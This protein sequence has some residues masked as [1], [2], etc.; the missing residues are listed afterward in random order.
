MD[1]AEELRQQAVAGDGVGDAGL[2]HHHH[3]HHRGQAGDGADLDQGLRGPHPNALAGASFGIGFGNNPLC[4]FDV[5]A[6]GQVAVQA[7]RAVASTGTTTVTSANG[8]ISIGIPFT[9]EVEID[10]A[11]TGGITVSLNG[12]SV[13]TGTL[14]DAPANSDSANLTRFY[15]F[16]SNNN[17]AAYANMRF[18]DHIFTQRSMSAGERTTCRSYV[19]EVGL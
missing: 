8:L 19:A 12:T 1:P 9:Y 2:A 6:S 11:S 5:G 4:R 10:F 17:T 13:A 3:Q 18:G 15:I 16:R 14:A 7:R